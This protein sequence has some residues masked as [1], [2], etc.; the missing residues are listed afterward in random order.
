MAGCRG[1]EGHYYRVEREPK[2][3]NRRHDVSD[4][5]ISQILSINEYKVQA[6]LLRNSEGRQRR[7]STQGIIAQIQALEYFTS[8][9][10]HHEGLG[11]LEVTPGKR[12]TPTIAGSSGIEGRSSLLGPSSIFRSFTS[13]P[14]K[15][16][17]S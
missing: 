16:M 17:Y 1:P 12:L 14:R 8:A 13:L 11:E 15:T 10:I 5:W 3:G 2:H 7:L 9:L 6:T 4:E